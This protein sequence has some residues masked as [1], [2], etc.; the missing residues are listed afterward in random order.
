MIKIQR[1]LIFTL[2]DHV[3]EIPIV[4]ALSLSVVLQ[5]MS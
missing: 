4:E 1:F 5:Y 2:C 3:E